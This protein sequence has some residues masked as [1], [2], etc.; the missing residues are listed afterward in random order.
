[1]EYDYYNKKQLDKIDMLTKSNPEKAVGLFQIYLEKFPNDYRAWFAYIKI[2]IVLKRLDDAKKVFDEVEYKLYIDDSIKKYPDRVF[3]NKKSMFLCRL[4]LLCYSNKY[5]EAYE[6]LIC[7]R[8]LASEFTLGRVEMFLK[9]KLGK[10][11]PFKE[12][13]PIYVY[14]QI[15]NYDEGQM[16]GYIYK[17]SYKYNETAEQKDN[18]IF[19]KDFNFNLVL[20]EVKKNIP[21]DN[22]LYYGLIEDMYFFKY[23]LCGTDDGKWTDHFKVICFHD[24]SDIITISPVVGFENVPCVDLNYLKDSQSPKVKQMSRID[25]FYNRYKK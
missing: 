14:N 25:K 2:L 20:S 23:D 19:A 10:L 12:K 13:S 1:M 18:N 11:Q 4:K 21:S 6:L 7:N 3:K 15:D 17:H 8:D 22:K 16:R 5:Q 9:K 24:T